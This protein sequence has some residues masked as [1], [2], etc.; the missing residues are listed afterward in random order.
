MEIQKL[1][2]SILNSHTEKKVISYTKKLIKKCSFNSGEC[3][4]NL[5]AL[6]YWLYV[7]GYED[8]VIKLCELTHDVEFPGKGMFN[9]WDYLLFMWGLEVCI[10]KK[11]GKN[12]EANERINIMDKYMSSSPLTG[13]AEIDRRNRFTYDFVANEDNIKTSY[14]NSLANEYRLTALYQLIGYTYTGLFPNLLKE[15]EKVESTIENY[16]S[17]LKLVK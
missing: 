16:I 5:C 15:K 9:V 17:I 11:N 14:S 4:S 6:T 8:E 7:Y 2:E 10:L 1:F 12:K 3:A 13:Q